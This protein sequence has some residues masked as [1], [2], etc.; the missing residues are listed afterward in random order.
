[1]TRFTPN[2]LLRPGRWVAALLV[3]AGCTSGSEM[4]GAS[5]AGPLLYVLNSSGNSV[6]AYGAAA[7]GDAAPRT[8]I[9]GG[10][11]STGLYA[12]TGVALDT[13]GH[14]YVANCCGQILVF[15]AG[16]TGNVTP[17]G[18]IGGTHTGLAY[19]TGVAFDAKGALYVSNRVATPSVTA[20]A[21]GAEG[22]IAPIDTIA[23]GETR[24]AAPN[25]IA[26][27]ASGRLYVANGASLNPGQI[28]IYAPGA[29]GNAAPI[30]SIAGSNTG[31]YSPT[32]I[33]FDASG[34]LYVT[35]WMPT[36]TSVLVYAA[37]A[38]GNA[39]PART[40]AGSNTGLN[41]T[42]G[43]SVDA[44]G[45]L[46]VTNPGANSVT[47]YAA[48][49]TGNAAPTATIQGSNTGLVEPGAIARDARGQLYV[50]SGLVGRITVF[51]GGAKGN[52]T[53]T[54]TVGAD[55]R[56][57]FV[58]DWGIARD[59][60]GNLYV[61]SPGN[62]TVKVYGAMANGPATPM[63]MIP[64]V[65][66]THQTGYPSGI[67]LDASGNLYVTNSQYRAAGGCCY[68]SITVFASATSQTADSSH[69]VDPVRTIT[70]SNTGL[71]APVA[72]AR[73]GAGNLYVA[74]RGGSCC[75]I[76]NSIT[77][78]AADANG[79][80]PPMATIAGTQT[81][82][83]APSGL[84]LDPQR[85]IYV[86]NTG[87]NSIT[88]YAPGT[89]GNASPLTTIAGAS[90]GLNGPT[91]IALDAGGNLYVANTLTNS[92]TVYAPG[93]RGNATPV[94]TISGGHTGLNGPVGVTF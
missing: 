66:P 61:T 23:G 79:N 9:L 43:V 82:L 88:I 48:G 57:S 68:P 85:S 87:G 56:P 7:S 26:F 84:A 44:A 83:N 76:D 93:A 8:A 91:G 42:G 18:A 27:D 53:P 72:I 30:D 16:T 40:I 20:Y 29:R 34:N 17:M 86:A 12:P 50:V 90:T 28:L 14:L 46:Y 4:T 52:A 54:A 1:M 19:P 63:A 59:P 77:V 33:A 69:P 58:G 51:A 71:N 55:P 32:W 41:G 75:G 2:S 37:G 62:N 39:V 45:T 70:G 94:A 60:A 10:G 15:A 81:G 6:T 35:N 21:P 31:L 38:H 49:A 67:A 5:G 47:I 36:S 73:D 13:A 64:T 78:Y 80:A 22:D 89:S 92:I 74:N 3:A 24:L 25:G 11:N 65:S